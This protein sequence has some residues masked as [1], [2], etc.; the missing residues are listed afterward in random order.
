MECTPAA[1]EVRF[2]DRSAHSFI[3]AMNITS[4]GVDVERID[5]YDEVAAMINDMIYSP[6]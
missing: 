3:S 2:L 4:N 6:E 5:R 1:G